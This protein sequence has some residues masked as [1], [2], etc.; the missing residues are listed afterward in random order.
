[1]PPIRRSLRGELQADGPL[2]SAAFAPDGKT[3]V[4]GTRTGQLTVWDLSTNKPPITRDG[5][6]FVNAVAFS[7]DG[8][9]L[10]TDSTDQTLIVWDTATW[11]IVR[12]IQ[13][14]RRPVF[15]LAFAPDGK[16]LAV[17]TTV[18][19][20]GGSGLTVLDAATFEPLKSVEPVEL[21]VCFVACS[22]DGK[23]SPHW[24]ADSGEKLALSS[25]S[26]IQAGEW[27]AARCGVSAVGLPDRVRSR[28]ENRGRGTERRVDRAV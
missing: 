18:S 5:H 22:P 19:Q 10:A 17:G 15:S 6:R 14:L 13:E 24:P 11:K 9:N 4:A 7:P 27:P 2:Q 20:G 16:T 25:F 21:P 1:M 3:L 28:R 26:A 8:K 23:R 12:T